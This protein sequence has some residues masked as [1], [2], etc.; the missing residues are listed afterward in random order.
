[1]D[2]SRNN[3]QIYLFWM[4][5]MLQCP[6]TND[7]S[8]ARDILKYHVEL[9][10]AQKNDVAYYEVLM[11]K[12]I[13][14]IQQVFP[15]LYKQWVK[16]RDEYRLE[17]ERLIID[18]LRDIRQIFAIL[19]SVLQ[20]EGLLKNSLINSSVAR[21]ELLLVCNRVDGR[22]QVMPDQYREAYHQLKYLCIDMLDIG[23]GD[24][25][26][27]YAEIRYS[28]EYKK[29]VIDTF[30]FVPSV[31]ILWKLQKTADKATWSIYAIFD[32]IKRGYDL[33][34]DCLRKKYLHYDSAEACSR[35]AKLLGWHGIYT[36]MQLVKKPPVDDGDLEFFYSREYIDKQLKLLLGRI[37][38]Q[39]LHTFSSDPMLYP[40]FIELRIDDFDKHLRLKVEWAPG[41]TEIL[42]MHTFQDCDLDK[43]KNVVFNY[44]SALFNN[45]GIM[46]KISFEQAT[47]ANAKKYLERVGFRGVLHK[48]FIIRKKN[49]VILKSTR[50]MLVGLSQIIVKNLLKHLMVLEHVEWDKT[51]H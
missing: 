24:L 40:V 8:I 31:E 18:I 13:P 44:F 42:H 4:I 17:S 23:R 41:L 25:I 29:Y 12:V 30:M 1:M 19:K 2:T 27:D 26:K 39:D 15:D 35:S 28:N 32:D 20:R 34:R 45:P 36:E 38:G 3:F 51:L 33:N 21:L 7:A 6:N 9:L 48:L 46:Q 16:E 5:N 37:F 10:H 50:V 14:L 47:G 22:P 49:N 11:T 43:E